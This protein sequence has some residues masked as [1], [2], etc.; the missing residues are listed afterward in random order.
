[1]TT[2]SNIA[3]T[4]LLSLHSRRIIPRSH[5]ADLAAVL[6]FRPTADVVQAAGALLS[7]PVAKKRKLGEPEKKSGAGGKGEG[8]ATPAAEPQAAEPQKKRLKVEDTDTGNGT[9]V[10]VDKT[11]LVP[12]SAGASEEPSI[13]ATQEAT[14]EGPPSANGEEERA[15]SERNGEKGTTEQPSTSKAASAK[16]GQ[17]AGT[18]PGPASGWPA[19]PRKRNSGPPP[20]PPSYYVLS[21]EDMRDNEYPNVIPGDPP[22]CPPGMARSPEAKKKANNCFGGTFLGRADCAI[23]SLLVSACS[24]CLRHTPH[25]QGGPDTRYHNL[26]AILSVQVLYRHGLLKKWRGPRSGRPWWQWTARW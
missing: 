19:F 17:R 11:S 23:R 9:S 22:T 5:I 16:P 3:R 2:H 20:F 24:Y 10:E 7:I 15:H 8:A 18:K 1:M 13:A 25:S 4:P 21:E 26:T 14:E 12:S 6:L